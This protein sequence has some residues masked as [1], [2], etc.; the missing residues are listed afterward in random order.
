MQQETRRA[1]RSSFNSHS[2]NMISDDKTNKKLYMFI[3]NKKSDRSG[4]ALLRSDGTSFYTCK[5]ADT[6][7]KQFSSV[8]TTKDVTCTPNLGLSLYTTFTQGELTRLDFHTAS[9][10]WTIIGPTTRNPTLLRSFGANVDPTTVQR[11]WTNAGQISARQ[12]FQPLPNVG[13]TIAY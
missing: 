2:N 6:L 13:P 11:C 1:C 7:N 12:Q 10:C 5:K 3:K 9:M 4:V 8:L